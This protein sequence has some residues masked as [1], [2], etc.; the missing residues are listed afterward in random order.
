MLRVDQATEEEIKSIIKWIDDHP[1][2]SDHILRE[3]SQYVT[4][5]ESF[6]FTTVERMLNHFDYVDDRDAY[7]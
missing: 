4:K 1:V 7:G 5:D 2:I 3:L 6:H